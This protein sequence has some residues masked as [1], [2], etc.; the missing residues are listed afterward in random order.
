ML[1]RNPDLKKNRIRRQI[2]F[3]LQS[4]LHDNLINYSI[5]HTIA[6]SMPSSLRMENPPI[7]KNP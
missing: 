3:L 1:A 4:L 2:S 7:Q 5:I 6:K